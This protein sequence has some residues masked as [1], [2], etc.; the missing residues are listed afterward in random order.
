MSTT[1]TFLKDKLTS[2]KYKLNQLES[3]YVAQHFK[4]TNAASKLKEIEETKT[5]TN[6]QIEFLNS[7]IKE[8]ELYLHPLN[9]D[10]IDW[11]KFKLDPYDWS[12]SSENK[13]NTLSTVSLQALTTEHLASLKSF[14]SLP[15]PLLSDELSKLLPLKI[16]TSHPFVNNLLSNQTTP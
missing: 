5:I 16:N 2:L 7:L 10:V 3:D 12:K 13:W 4:F 1:T 14:P 6:S 9:A 11:S 15:Q 8:S